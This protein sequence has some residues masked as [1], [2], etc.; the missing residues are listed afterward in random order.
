MKYPQSVH[1]KKI[2]K[3][4]QSKEIRGGGQL[5]NG[6]DAI[7]DHQKVQ[8]KEIRKR[9]TCMPVFTVHYYYYFLLFL[10]TSIFM[11]MNLKL[12]VIINGI[13]LPSMLVFKR[14]ILAIQKLYLLRWLVV[15]VLK[16][17]HYFFVGLIIT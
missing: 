17:I 8:N 14:K 16:V 4:A 6:K 2:K 12:R 10:L 3:H 5:S 11:Y 1:W 7:I 9:V 15:V 13:H